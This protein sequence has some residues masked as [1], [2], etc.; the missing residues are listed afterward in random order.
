MSIEHVRDMEF[1]LGAGAYAWKDVGHEVA[2]LLR[3]ALPHLY[4]DKGFNAE[5]LARLAD[6]GEL[7]Q[8]LDAYLLGNGHVLSNHHTHSD[9]GRVRSGFL[10]DYAELAI[11]RIDSTPPEYTGSVDENRRLVQLD[12]RDGSELQR[13]FR[14]NGASRVFRTDQLGSGYAERVG[15]SDVP[16]AIVGAGGA[17]IVSARFLSNLGFRNI[18]MFDKRGR[19]TGI[20]GQDNVRNGSKN[21]PFDI[22]YD[23]TTARSA[24]EVDPER[25]GRDIESFLE[26]L[27]G[28]D[29]SGIPRLD[30]PKKA[31][32]TSIEPGDL[33]HTIRYKDG[34]EEAT[35]A[36]PIV[37]YAPGVGE[38]LPPSHPGHMET[39]MKSNEVGQR[40]QRQLNPEELSEL[41]GKRVILVGL[42]NS[43]A[44]ML[45][46]FHKHEQQT[47]QQIDYRILTHQ[48]PV[49]VHN[50]KRTENGQRVYRNIALPE[51]SHL[52]GDLDHID[53]V[54]KKALERGKIISDVAEWSHEGNVM[55]VTT[56]DGLKTDIPFDKQYTLI[57]YGQRPSTNDAMGLT[58]I[59]DY[60]GLI[61]HDWDGEVQADTDKMGRDRLH[62]G[63]FA[64]GPILRSS[65]NPNALVLPGM[66][67]QLQHMIPSLM[68]RAAEYAAKHDHPKPSLRKV[69]HVR[70]SSEFEKNM[71]SR[72]VDRLRYG[73][74]PKLE[75]ELGRTAVGPIIIEN[76]PEEFVLN[77]PTEGKLRYYRFQD[78][79]GR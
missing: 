22:I 23:T 53:L 65:K 17:G 25:S 12:L 9:S 74:S 11:N 27:V 32:V 56:H 40:W 31:R 42:G 46:Q 13:D 58:T 50:P 18:T 54:Y 73:M 51:L 76:L 67:W 36:F 72:V 35:Q 71:P 26:R 20:W 47:G 39:P 7:G 44:E 2:P 45:L 8:L 21:N 78:K 62:P 15:V 37:I 69:P 70:G 64:I 75:Q 19:F 4:V 10:N 14:R 29:L 38:P 34:D 6:H 5:G 60:T 16:V 49:L 28:S 3:E 55:T 59:D 61:L 52:A 41:A 33:N 1:E 43:T 68:I 48:P 66:Q 77:E 79:R 24:A 63:Y 57:G 30:G